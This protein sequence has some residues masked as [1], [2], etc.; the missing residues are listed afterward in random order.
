MP[1]VL[2]AT[3]GAPDANSFLTVERASE[4]L[5]GR[6]NTEAWDDAAEL[7][8][9]ALVSGTREISLYRYK[10][11][12]S[13]DT[14]AL[15]FPRRGLKDPDVGE[16]ADDVI[17]ERVEFALAELAL[18]LLRDAAR[19]RDLTDTTPEPQIR[20]RKVDVI[21]REWFE[22]GEEAQ[23]LAR[24]PDVVAWLAPFL[25]ATTDLVRT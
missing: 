10:G 22:A 3:P 16:I 23:G 12:R 15:P 21:E 14:Q 8:E 13:S 9:R 25:A 17:P 6:L 20:R 2:I 4:I 18:A 19:G 11:E 5:A 7:R 1:L 24:A